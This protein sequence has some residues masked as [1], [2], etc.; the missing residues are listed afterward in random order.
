MAQTSSGDSKLQFILDE[1]VRLQEE[2]LLIH[3]RTI[4]SA[5]GAWITV[6]G[7][8]VWLNSG[9]KSCAKKP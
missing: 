4:E 7:R 9:V 8:K 3:L 1:R 6:D 2:G 5:Q